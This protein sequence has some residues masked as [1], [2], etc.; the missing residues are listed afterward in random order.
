MTDFCFM[1]ICHFL[2]GS[3]SIDQFVSPSG[4]PER[5]SLQIKRMSHWWVEEQRVNVQW[6][7]AA[8]EI[9]NVD[10][11]DGRQAIGL[12]RHS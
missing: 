10:R 12:P 7:S 8:N 2:I 9:E 5:V 11:L 6:S 3:P 1:V 4:E